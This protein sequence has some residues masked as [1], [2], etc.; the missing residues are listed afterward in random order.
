MRR[1]AARHLAA[2]HLRC[3]PALVHQPGRGLPV[4][5]EELVVQASAGIPPAG[6]SPDVHGGAVLAIGHAG[7]VCGFWSTIEK[8]LQQHTWSWRSASPIIGNDSA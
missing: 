4:R 8:A 5:R 7:V 6:P 2:L 1:Q 3:K